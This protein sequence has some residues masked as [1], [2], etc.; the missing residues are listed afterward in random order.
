SGSVQRQSA[1]VRA[2]VPRQFR[3][4]PDRAGQGR[5]AGDGRHRPVHPA[6]F[7]LFRDRRPD[8]RRLGQGE[9]GTRGQGGRNRHHGPRAHRLHSAIGAA[10]AR[11][12]VP[13]GPA[14]DHLWP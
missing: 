10:A 6:L 3:A 5:I 7:P 14:F 2:A 11:L 1:Q 4:V 9:A 8:C 13:D 12:P